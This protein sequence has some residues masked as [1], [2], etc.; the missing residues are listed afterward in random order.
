MRK[1]PEH[2]RSW[3]RKGEAQSRPKLLITPEERKDVEN[4]RD[5]P[6]AFLMGTVESYAKTVYGVTQRSTPCRKADSDP[7]RG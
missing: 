6:Y 4:N 3:C 5:N 2:W 7:N 1:I